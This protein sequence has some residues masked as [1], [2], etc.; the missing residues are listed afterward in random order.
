MS[1]APTTAS[2]GHHYCL[3]LY[4]NGGEVNYWM[5]DSILGIGGVLLR[6]KIRSIERIYGAR[7]AA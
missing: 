2:A 7:R 6:R 3:T 5:Y 4:R 1:P